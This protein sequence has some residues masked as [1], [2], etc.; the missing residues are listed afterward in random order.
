RVISDEEEQQ[1]SAEE[2]RRREGREGQLDQLVREPVV[3]GLAGAPADGL[4]DHG[5]DRNAEDER[6]EVQMQLRDGP[7][8]EPRAQHGKRAVRGVFGV[9]GGGLR[10]DGE[11]GEYGEREAKEDEQPGG[12]PRKGHDGKTLSKDELVPEVT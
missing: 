5:E 3:P 6:G 2:G 12:T 10:V 9:L 7:H 11:G 8:R 4:D 1:Q